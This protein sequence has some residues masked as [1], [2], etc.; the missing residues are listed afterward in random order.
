MSWFEMW[1][2]NSCKPKLIFRFVNELKRDAEKKVHVE[3]MQAS[4]TDLQMVIPHSFFLSAYRIHKY[5]VSSP[6][7]LTV[8]Q[9]YCTF[10]LSAYRTHNYTVSSHPLTVLINTLYLLLIRLPY[11]LK[12]TV[13]SR[14]LTVPM[15]ILYFLL[16][17]LPNP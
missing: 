10:F 9:I 14:P 6:Y 11:A 3:Q 2:E 5:T 1:C 17:H 16:I 12:Y 13:T 8:I 15:N 7:L 4:I